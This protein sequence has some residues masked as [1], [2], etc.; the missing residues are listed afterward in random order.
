MFGVWWEHETRE[1]S[2]ASA[3][4]G[5][6]KRY[7]YARRV[8]ALVSAAP[9]GAATRRCY[10]SMR[11]FHQIAKSQ[12]QT[13]RNAQN[14][15]HRVLRRRCG[16]EREREREREESECGWYAIGKRRDVS[17]A[18][19]TEYIRG[20][21]SRGF[22]ICSLVKAVAEQLQS[23]GRPR[24]VPTS[25]AKN[26][27]CNLASTALVAYFSR[28]TKTFN[29]ARS[30]ETRCKPRHDEHWFGKEIFFQAE[31]NLSASGPSNSS[32]SSA[33]LYGRTRSWKRIETFNVSHFLDMFLGSLCFLSELVI[34]SV[35]R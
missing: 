11:A 12:R 29:F 22:T 19:G 31:E 8:G 9:S 33:S 27:E 21:V 34:F 17:V 6:Y 1:V 13:A 2:I 14:E 28:N 10:N 5:E 4:Q 3:R 18:K 23:L 30:S 35:P 26:Y 25:F 32:D 20:K 15:S 7:I 16:T 24:E